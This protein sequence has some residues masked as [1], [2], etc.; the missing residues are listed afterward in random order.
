MLIINKA[1][2]KRQTGS[3]V[4]SSSVCSGVKTHC[5]YGEMEYPAC[6]GL[7]KCKI[8]F[9]NMTTTSTTTLLVPPGLLH[10]FMNKWRWRARKG[11]LRTVHGKEY[12]R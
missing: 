9:G 6:F 12:K 8:L 11:T 10:F 7:S 2:N 1:H 3:R 5:P 4:L